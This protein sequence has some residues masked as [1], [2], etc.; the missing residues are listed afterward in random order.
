MNAW[1]LLLPQWV[2]ALFL[3]A[4]LVG[5][6]GWSTAAGQRIGLGVAGY[7]MAFAIVG[8]PFN[9]YWG[10]LTAPLF[11][12]SASAFPAAAGDLW[13]AAFGR[14]TATAGLAPLGRRPF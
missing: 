10:S 9:Q 2:T 3:V 7:V 11:A 1:L 13:R 6:A 14:S 12:L 5:A 8:Q 4:A